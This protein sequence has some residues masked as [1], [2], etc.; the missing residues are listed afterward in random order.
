MRIRRQLGALLT[1]AVLTAGAALGTVAPAQAY[2]PD[3][4]VT[5]KYVDTD[6]CP[7]SVGDPYDG[8]YFRHD[9]GGKAVKINLYHPDS[10]AW[11]GKVEFHPYGEKLWVYDTKNDGDTFY[12]QLQYASVTN[13]YP[14]GPVVSAP[15]TSAAVEY[16]TYDYNLDEGGAVHVSV[17]DDAGKDDL[18]TSTGAVIP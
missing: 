6:N 16:T 2:N 17:Y 5:F 9:P 15:G 10:G 12:V 14:V 8:T 4:R 1:G 18:I 11:L 3:P 7:C 13:V